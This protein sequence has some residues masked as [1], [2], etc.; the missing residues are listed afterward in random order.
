[1]Y[2]NKSPMFPN[3][4]FPL[5]TTCHL[6]IKSGIP[7]YN[8]HW[9]CMQH[10]CA[11][12]TYMCFQTYVNYMTVYSKCKKKT[13]SMDLDAH[14]NQ[15]ADKCSIFPPTIPAWLYIIFNFNSDLYEPV[16]PH[17]EFVASLMTER[18]LIL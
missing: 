1:V 16:W 13:T 11:V 18:L 10:E 4:I 9:F 12:C 8:G 17:T 6:W 7:C 3:G 15:S 2:N 5:Q 14:Q